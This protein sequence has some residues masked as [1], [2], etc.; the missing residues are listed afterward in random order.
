LARSFVIAFALAIPASSR[1]QDGRIGGTVRTANG[2]PLSNARITVTNTAGG[3][4]RSAAT[5]ADGNYT[6]TRLPDGSY[7]VSVAL[8]GYR[9]GSQLNVRVPGSAAVD[10]TLEVLPLQA[11]TVTATL[12][13]E[14]LA[15]VPFSVAA[16]TASVLRE[17][18]ADNIEAIAA[19]VA[20]FSVQNLGPGQSQ[21]SA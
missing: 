21:S 8:V 1:A 11:I 4:T 10:F 15:D 6:V 14:E 18:G 2:T 13:E 17:R 9:P 20:G 12:R 5:S 7:T 19:E 16:P 3:V